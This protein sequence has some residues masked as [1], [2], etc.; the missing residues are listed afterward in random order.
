MQPSADVNPWIP[1]GAGHNRIA[2][3]ITEIVGTVPWA[4]EGWDCPPPT[5]SDCVPSRPRAKSPLWRAT[6]HYNYDNSPKPRKSALTLA[7]PRACPKSDHD[8]PGHPG[9]GPPEHP[10]YGTPE[11]PRYGTPEH[12]RYGIPDASGGPRSCLHA[13]GLPSNFVLRNWWMCR[14]ASGTGGRTVPLGNRQERQDRIP[15]LP[16]ANWEL[17]PARILRAAVSRQ[18]LA[19]SRPVV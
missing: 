7:S 12:P 11:H 15:L 9:Y 5:I 13:T 16:T 10:R 4:A 8:P 1:P 6:R 19:V 2:R 3:D 14:S 18:P 17:E